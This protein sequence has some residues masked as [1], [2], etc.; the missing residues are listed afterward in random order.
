V[1]NPTV[2]VP[3]VIDDA[4][5]AEAERTGLRRHQ[6]LEDWFV[7]TW[8]DYVARNLRRDLSRTAEII[9]VTAKPAT[10][11]PG[12]VPSDG[13]RIVTTYD[14]APG[15][16]PRGAND[17]SDSTPVVER[18]RTARRVNKGASGGTTT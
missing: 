10:C 18:D 9:D 3:V 2:A 8:P 17:E 13:R 16:L 12:H 5:R 14:S 7:R 6:V 15:L 4:I 11:R 1:L